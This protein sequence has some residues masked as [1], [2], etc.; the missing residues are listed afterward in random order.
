M[1]ATLASRQ[2]ALP[3]VSYA[4][5]R[6]VINDNHQHALL[7]D[8]LFRSRVEPSKKGKGS[9]RRHAKHGTRWEPGQQRMVMVCC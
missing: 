6:G 2:E 5:Q 4:H 7:G 9:Y 1:P 3:T 8:P